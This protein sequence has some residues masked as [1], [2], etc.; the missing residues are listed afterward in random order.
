[1]YPR[2]S[3]LAA[4]LIVLTATLSSKEDQRSQ[5]LGSIDL[6]AGATHTYTFSNGIIQCKP[7]QSGTIYTRR[8]Y[9]NFSVSFEFRLPAGGNNGLAIRYPGHGIP[10]YAG[11]CELQVLDNSAARYNDLDPRQYHGSAYGMVAARKG[12]LKPVGEWNQQTVTVIGSAIRVELNGEPILDAN[13]SEVTEF[14]QNKA[15]PG[16]D[17]RSGHF[18]LAGHQS[19]VAFRNIVISEITDAH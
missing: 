15:H 1:M 9:A 16:K 10:A 14:M 19:P 12:A 7:G 17:L 13:L 18:G 8:Q 6:W 4:C 2:H 11:M 5:S 3:F